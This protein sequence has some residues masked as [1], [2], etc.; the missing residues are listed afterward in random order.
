MNWTPNES[1][2]Y[3]AQF[4]VGVNPAGIN[5]TMLDPL[6]R[7]TL[8]NGVAVDD[9]IYGGSVNQRV[10]TVN[11][12]SSRYSTFDEEELTNY[13]VGFKGNAFE[14]RLTYAGAVYFMEWDNALE[15]IALDWDY[16][17][18]DNDLAGTLVTDDDPTGPAGVYYVP[19]SDNTSI[20]N[21]LTN[22]GVS[23]TVGV[24]LQMSYQINDN[25]SISGNASVMKREFTDYCSE[26]DFLG[27]DGST[28]HPEPGV[29]AGLTE[30]VSE[31][32]NP[33]WILDGLEVADQPSLTMTVIPRYQT[34][35]GDGFRFTASVMLRHT[36]QHYRTF[37]NTTETPV[38]NRANLRLGLAKDAWSGTLYI[39]NLLD[40]RKLTPRGVT[41]Q[42][43]FNSLNA[44]AALPPEYLFPYEGA[45]MASFRFNPNIGRTYGI[46]VSYDF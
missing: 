9:T 3:Y 25:W 18:A 20:N 7:A 16:A 43:R 45:T 36:G 13:E 46:R 24:E 5:A 4:S 2:T 21:V 23:D 27:Y 35:L 10:T 1:T 44:P 11:Y 31:G 8:D 40:D 29:Y 12:D 41:D 39:D 15:N 32:G 26:D 42:N 22:T 33:C 6:L 30:G 34:V 28:T 19:T 37:A 14:G 17:Y 38:V